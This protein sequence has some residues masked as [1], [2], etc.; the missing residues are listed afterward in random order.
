VA[1]RHPRWQLLQSS[2]RGVRCIHMRVGVHWLGVPHATS[3]AAFPAQRT[4]LVHHPSAQ[5]CSAVRD[6]A[7]SVWAEGLFVKRLGFECAW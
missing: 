6:K 4:E 1:D 5:V 7:R 2:S 3:G